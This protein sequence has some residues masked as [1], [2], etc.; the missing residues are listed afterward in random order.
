[1]ERSDIIDVLRL[2]Y[3]HLRAHIKAL[4]PLIHK[5]ILNTESRVFTLP[6]L[7]QDDIGDAF[8]NITPTAVNNVLARNAYLD[9]TLDMT[10][11]HE[12]TGQMA[13]RL[14]GY[15][16]L[17]TPDEAEILERIDVI[18]SLKKNLDAYIQTHAGKTPDT[19]FEV[20]SKAI[21]N[22]VRKALSRRLLV[23]PTDTFSVSFSW[24]HSSSRSKAQP[25]AYW[26]EKLERSRMNK[27]AHIDE[28]AWNTMIDME[29]KALMAANDATHF[30]IMRPLR[31]NPIINVKYDKEDDGI[32]KKT[33]MI[34][35]SPLL[36]L[37]QEPKCFPLRPYQGASLKPAEDAPVIERWHLYKVM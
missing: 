18:N 15:I 17:N 30:R 31:V 12:Q 16:L 22:L 28:D 32:F 9:H 8:P 36:L 19:R 7:S 3:A 5:G 14:P 33:T 24:S 35:H 10:L 25:T 29:K 20:V 34:A 26:E 11:Q 1:M 27:A 4:H 23:A 6:L 2:D 37:N 13:K 21:P